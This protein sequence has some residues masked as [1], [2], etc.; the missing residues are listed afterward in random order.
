M[1]AATLRAWLIGLIFVAAVLSYIGSSQNIQVVYGLGFG[2]FLVAVMLYA[3][4]R[5]AVRNER[6]ATVFD[7]E[8]KTDETGT[9]ADQ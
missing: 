4:W 7:R 3:F 9:R 5:R 8:A 1:R 2:V 6:A